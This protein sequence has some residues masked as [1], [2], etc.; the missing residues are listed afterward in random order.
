MCCQVEVSATSWSL[1]QRSSTDCDASLCVIKKPQKWGGHGPRGAA[2]PQK[3][4]QTTDVW[5]EIGRVTVITTPV[6]RHYFTLASEEVLCAS[7]YTIQVQ[8]CSFLRAWRTPTILQIN[9]LS[10]GIAYTYFFTESRIYI[11][12]SARQDGDIGNV[13][14][15]NVLTQTVS[16]WL[17]GWQGDW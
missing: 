17:A 7:E 11:I 4:K 1:V 3:T 9:D 12:I 15:V 8:H 6:S 14:S 10:D 2:A 13:K 16:L 5:T